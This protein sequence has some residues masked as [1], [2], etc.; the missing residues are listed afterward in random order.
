[1]TNDELV[2]AALSTIESGNID[3]S[4]QYFA[5]NMTFSGPVPEPVG[6]EAFLHV[7]RAMLQG[8]PD[9]KFN[10]EK[11]GEEENAVTG[12]L[13]ITGTHTNELPSIMPGLP[14]IAATNRS[15]SIPTEEIKFTVDGGKIAAVEVVPVPNGGVAGLLGQLGR[16]LPH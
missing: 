10:F 3:E 8:I 6:K 9:W 2:H 11:T 16:E 15:V 7:H 4:A 14:A 1:M 12:R 13:Q 5:D